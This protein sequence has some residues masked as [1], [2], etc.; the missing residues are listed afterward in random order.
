[1]WS[2]CLISLK[3]DKPNTKRKNYLEGEVANREA[4][5]G[6]RYKRQTSL[7]VPVS[8]IDFE[9]YGSNIK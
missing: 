3:K 6:N 8:Q 7:N 2:Y 4:G 5:W 9:S 1:M